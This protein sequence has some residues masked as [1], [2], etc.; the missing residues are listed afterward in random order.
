MNNKNLVATLSTGIILL[1]GG[2]LLNQLL[3]YNQP[4]YYS[5]Y[6]QYEYRYNYA[7]NS[8]S[9]YGYGYNAYNYRPYG[10]YQM[11]SQSCSLLLG[12]RTNYN[13]YMYI[14]NALDYTY[15]QNPGLLEPRYMSNHQWY[16]RGLWPQQFYY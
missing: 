7:Y 12:C 16:A 9:N 2:L 4:S 8:Y 11:P 3:S 14:N 5:Q 10:P 1:F 6:N 13:S 15:Y